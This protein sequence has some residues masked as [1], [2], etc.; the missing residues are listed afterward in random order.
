MLARHALQYGHID[1][2]LYAI[3]KFFKLHTIKNTY[4]CGFRLQSWQRVHS[5]WRLTCNGRL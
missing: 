2:C 4:I 1:K 5:V 3:F